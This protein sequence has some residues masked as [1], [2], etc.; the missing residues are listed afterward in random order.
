[1]L[2][3]FSDVS[4]TATAA[5]V[6]LFA[7]TLSGL[8]PL[9]DGSQ[10]IGVASTTDIITNGLAVVAK[11]VAQWN[12]IFGLFDADSHRKHVLGDE[13][14]AQCGNVYGVA[15]GGVAEVIGLG[16]QCF[17]YLRFYQALDR[18]SPDGF[19]ALPVHRAGRYVSFVRY[20]APV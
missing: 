12:R 5:W 15:V 6:R 7:L 9:G 8:H 4:Q 16:R 11:A 1:M 20:D 14:V 19:R 10:D 2:D 17:S 3:G 18:P 13:V